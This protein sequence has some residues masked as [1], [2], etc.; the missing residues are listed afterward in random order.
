MNK[1]IFIIDD[2][3]IYRMIVAKTINR[4][5][6]TLR[7]TE[8]ENGE[9][10]LAELEKQKDSKNEIIVLLDINMPIL[11]GWGFLTE[12]EKSKFYNIDNL[13]IYMVSSSIDESD[14]VRAKQYGFVKG[15]YH[16]P[17]SGD[18]IKTLAGIGEA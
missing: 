14:K 2:D 4:V 17:L 15:F 1:E 13:V 18:D 12:I 8:C 10:G 3:L 9:I 7:T 5:D 16:K 6:S 11:D